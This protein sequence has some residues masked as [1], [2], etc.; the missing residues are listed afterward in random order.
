MKRTQTHRTTALSKF[1]ELRRRLEY[2]RAME[3][4]FGGLGVVTRDRWGDAFSQ[5]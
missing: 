4:F 5:A 1:T 2:H 3:F